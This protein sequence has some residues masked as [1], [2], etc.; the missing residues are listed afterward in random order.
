M[1]APNSGSAAHQVIIQTS[2]APNSE[3]DIVADL[4]DESANV[5][6]RIS[7]NRCNSFQKKIVLTLQSATVDI[8]DGLGGARDDGLPE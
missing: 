3:V 2:S 1:V 7:K 4:L 8:F 5:V 6:K